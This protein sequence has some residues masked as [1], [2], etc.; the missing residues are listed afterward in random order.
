MSW[1]IIFDSF[2]PFLIYH[3]FLSVKTDKTTES[4][5]KL[6]SGPKRSGYSIKTLNFAIITAWD[7]WSGTPNSVVVPLY[8]FFALFLLCPDRGFAYCRRWIVDLHLNFYVWWEENILCQN[9]FETVRGGGGKRDTIKVPVLD[10][11]SSTRPHFSTNQQTYQP[12]NQP[13]NH[14]PTNQPSKPPT[15]KPT[16]FKHQP[17]QPTNQPTNQQT[18]C[19]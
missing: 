15:N 16:P 8:I 13:T 18:H 9:P 10:P 2:L 3:F 12:F 14:Q 11:T 5:E 6:K 19:L 7:R 4:L 1:L 17:T